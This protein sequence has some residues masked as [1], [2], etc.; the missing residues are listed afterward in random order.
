MSKNYPS[1]W[2]TLGNLVTL[3]KCIEV[4]SGEYLED[5]I[6]FV[7]VS[8]LSSFEITEEKYISEELYAEIQE[9]QPQ[10]GEILLSKREF[11]KS[12]WVI[13]HW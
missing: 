4:G 13:E 2:D 9:H 1:G 10:K 6:P 11:E 8:N 7:R 3:K 5:G 12:L